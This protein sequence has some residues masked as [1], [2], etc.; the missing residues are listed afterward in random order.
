[1]ESECA[2][3]TLSRVSL[4]VYQDLRRMPSVLVEWGVRSKVCCSFHLT[5]SV[6]R[7]DHSRL[8]PHTSAPPLSGADVIQ[9]VN[10]TVEIVVAS[11]MRFSDTQKM[12]SFSLWLLCRG[13]HL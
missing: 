12:L 8:Q 10:Q 9:Y 11:D 6:Q 3:K 7:G 13:S 4:L 5:L 1:M 2:L